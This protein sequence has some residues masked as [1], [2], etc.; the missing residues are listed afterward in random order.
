M[1]QIAIYGKGG[2]GKSTTSS[3]LSAAFARAGKKVLHIGCDPKQ[4]STKNLLKG[5]I[6]KSVLEIL[7]EKGEPSRISLDEIVSVGF[8]SVHCVEAG[9]PE[10]G[11]GCAG[12]GIITAFEIIKELD[13]YKRIDP[14]IVIYDILGDVVCGGFSMPIRNGYAEEIFLITSG[15]MMSLYAANNICK[16]IARFTKQSKVK[17]AGV[18]CNS[19]NISNEET[20]VGDFATSIGSNLVHFIPRDVAVQSCES[21]GMTVIEG[22]P[23]CKMSDQYSMLAEKVINF[24]NYSDP[25]PM[26]NDQ[27]ERF[28]KK[29]YVHI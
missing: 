16:A 14:D 5:K 13:G 29:Y 12:R 10:P 4:D 23:D 19:K 6:C 28:I 25:K 1:R 15:E 2:I 21:N 24:K 27:F 26:D 9:G 17:L 7:Q 20:I 11:V 8:G 18:I 22:M 3:N